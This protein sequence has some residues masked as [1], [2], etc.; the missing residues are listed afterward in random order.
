VSLRQFTVRA[1]FTATFALALAAPVSAVAQTG[2]HV[3]PGS[4]A[5]QEYAVPLQA[6]RGDFDGGKTKTETNR[7]TTKVAPATRSTP[8]TTSQPAPPPSFGTGIT[9]AETKP[10][11]PA[12]AA[13]R[14]GKPKTTHRT[15]PVEPRLRD[16][17]ADSTVSTT[18][19][20]GGIVAAV[21]LIALA[22]VAVTRRPRRTTSA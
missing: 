3:D 14:A 1:G 6:T 5:G 16:V 7:R 10:K 9:K 2:V 15:T 20:T 12:R 22:V 21:L 17:N 13:P 18:A 4:P 11:R 19:A 8:A